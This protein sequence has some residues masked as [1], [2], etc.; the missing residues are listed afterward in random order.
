MYSKLPSLLSLGL[1]MGP[2]LSCGGDGA[3]DVETQVSSRS[4]KGHEGDT[5]SN[6][7]VAVY[8]SIV[9]TRLDD[10]QTCHVG[11]IE[12]GKL[13][14]SSCD[15]CHELVLH[16]GGGTARETL[17]A[18]GLDYLEA[19]RSRD[20]IERIKRRDSDGDG[21]S[22]DAELGA[23]RYPGSQRSMP[24]QVVATLRTVTVEQLQAMPSHRQF[25]LVNTTRQPFDDYVDYRGVKIKDL[26]AARD[27]DLAG[28]TGITLI[29]PDGYMKSIPIEQ[30]TASFPQPLF[31]SGLDTETLGEG[32]GV[33][34]YPETV[35]DGLSDG[36]PIPGEQWLMLAYERDGAPLD[37]SRLDVARGKIV[38]EGPLRAVV[39]Q[40]YP[41]RPDRGSRVSPTECGDGLDFSEGADHNAGA[42]VRGV[43]AVRI[44]PM[45]AGVEEYDT[46]NGGWAHID[47]GELILYGHNVR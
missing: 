19:G 11:R 26:L 20:A 12:D 47:A 1:L 28:A 36:S 10:C 16:G 15:R 8:P 24:G 22:N 29:A 42:M 31:H 40:K 5:D 7:L 4:Y 33:A 35:P 2:C 18:F 32:C 27:I 46:M 3:A 21:H 23:G 45:P 17:N 13:A 30:V 14:G 6:N 37:T 44:D 25:L 43:I 9:G 34:R 38:G 41:G 39:P